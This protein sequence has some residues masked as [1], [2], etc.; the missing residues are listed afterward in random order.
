MLT[1]RIPLRHRIAFCLSPTRSYEATTTGRNESEH[2][3]LKG[4]TPVNDSTPISK[5]AHLDSR[6]QEYRLAMTKR[7]A[8]YQSVRVPV[9]E[10]EAFTEGQGGPRGFI[11]PAAVELLNREL[12]NASMLQVRFDTQTQTYLIESS[13]DV[14]DSEPWNSVI[15]KRTRSIRVIDCSGRLHLRCSC[16]FTMEYGLPCRHILAVNELL[17]DLEDVDPRWLKAMATGDLDHIL[18]QSEA[19]AKEMLNLPYLRRSSNDTVIVISDEDEFDSP[20]ETAEL[21]STV[22]DPPQSNRS[23]TYS[24]ILNDFT[25]L[26][27]L[28]G[29]DPVSLAFVEANVRRIKQDLYERLRSRDADD[30]EASATGAPQDPVLSA[31]PQGKPSSRRRKAAHES[32]HRKKRKSFTDLGSGNP[33]DYESIID[34]TGSQP[35]RKRKCP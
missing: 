4:T 1:H 11:T 12:A 32:Q 13:S 33:T 24:S 19:T 5:T 31:R 34:V 10:V 9:A 8:N 18:F 6:R 35:G 16:P 27:H 26:M 29:E 15:R 28:V 2:S 14:I 25:S 30:P 20:P 22:E 17:W 7:T 3:A 23:P 21:P